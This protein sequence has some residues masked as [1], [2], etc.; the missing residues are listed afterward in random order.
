MHR[1][2]RIVSIEIREETD[3]VSCRQSAKR[4]AA[5]LDLSPLEQ[6]RFATSVSE[7]ARNVYQYA[8]GGAFHFDLAE[9][10][11][12]QLCGLTFTAEDQGPGIAAIE[13]IL[14]GSYVSPTGMGVGLRG[15]QRL[16]DSF[17]IQTSAAGTRGRGAR[18]LCHPL[19][20]EDMQGGAGARMRTQQPP[21]R[22]GSYRAT[23]ATLTTPNRRRLPTCPIAALATRRDESGG[24]GPAPSRT[25]E[26]PTK[27]PS[28]CD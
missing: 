4:I 22:Q 1:T 28:I 14:D 11:S 21:D 17:D 10:A 18:P 24:D 20:K 13:Q 19:L 25:T 3:V 5:W 16:M 15:A 6:I 23:T 12:G 8:G 2:R 27:A 9:N 26:S 7:L